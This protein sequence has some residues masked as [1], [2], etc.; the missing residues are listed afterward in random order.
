MPIKLN[1]DA[2]LKK[3]GVDVLYNYGQDI[4]G[5]Y[6]KQVLEIGGVDTIA[7]MLKVKTADLPD[8]A[9]GDVFEFCIDDVDKEC[10]AKSFDPERSGFTIIMLE[11]QP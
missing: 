1:L 2:L 7:E 6:D 5:I 4:R 11:L 9:K 8:L 3:F 10:K